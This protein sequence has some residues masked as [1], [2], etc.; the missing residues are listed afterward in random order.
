M[1]R[2]ARRAGLAAALGALAGGAGCL[3]AP[4]APPP[5]ATL[6]IRRPA[7]YPETILYDAQSRAFLVSSLRDGGI[8]A[9]DDSGGV[10]TR[11]KDPRLCSVLGIALDASRGRL[12]AVNADLGVSVRPSSAGRSRL[13]GVAVYD[14]ASGAP[15][16]YAD[17]ASLLAAPHLLN[18]IAVDDATG[19]AFVSDSFAPAI[20]RIRADGTARVFLQ[21]QRFAG[22]GINLNGLVVHPDGYLLIVKKSEG[23]LFKVPLADPAAFQ[24]VALDQPLLG[25]DGVMLVGKG[26]LVVVA[27][28]V[29]TAKANAAYVLSSDDGWKTARLVHKDELGEVYPTTSVMRDGRVFVLSSQLDELISAPLAEQ[30]SLQRHA[31][32]APLSLFAP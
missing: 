26:Q 30:P 10:A 31:V 21:S 1:H 20:Y 28:K 12:W 27:N 22:P 24:E 5:I 19:D 8:Y 13:A 3:R 25:A 9:V 29:P 6:E 2:T 7:L 32:I 17:L 15:Q 16:A 11:V 14:A 23:L 18:G 4:V